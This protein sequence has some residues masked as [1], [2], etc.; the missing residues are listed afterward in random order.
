MQLI[1]QYQKHSS[2]NVFF[3]ILLSHQSLF[4]K[5]NSTSH[6]VPAKEGKRTF[7]RSQSEKYSVRIWAV[8]RYYF[9]QFYVTN[10]YLD[11]IYKVLRFYVFLQRQHSS[12]LYFFSRIVQKLGLN[13]FSIMFY[14]VL[15]S[16]V[17]QGIKKSFHQFYLGSNIF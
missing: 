14:S 5:D 17:L 10:T 13:T 16:V 9:S 8:Q 7:A 12:L 2:C 4:R 6:Y 1:Y 15:I 11:G 3:H